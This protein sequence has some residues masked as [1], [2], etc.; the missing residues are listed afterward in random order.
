MEKYQVTRFNV[1]TLHYW[2]RFVV[3]ILHTGVQY[4]ESCEGWGKP[5]K[6]GGDFL[7]ESLTTTTKNRSVTAKISKSTQTGTPSTGG[8]EYR[9]A[10]APKKNVETI[11]R[12]EALRKIEVYCVVLWT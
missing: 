4:R 2:S 3:L 5:Q 9:A 11:H 12:Q 8:G 1:G 6:L 7:V 10:P